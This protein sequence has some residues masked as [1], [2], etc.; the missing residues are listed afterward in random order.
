MKCM[1]TIFCLLDPA[2][3]PQNPCVLSCK[4][5]CLMKLDTVYRFPMQV[6]K[7]CFS[8]VAAANRVFTWAGLEI[9]SMSH[10]RAHRK[11][12]ILAAQPRKCSLP[13]LT[14]DIAC[15]KGRTETRRRA[16]FRMRVNVII[17]V[18]S[19]TFL[20]LCGIGAT[21][22]VP[23]NFIAARA[24]IATKEWARRI[25]KGPLYAVY[26]CVNYKMPLYRKC[27]CNFSSNLC[28]S[29]ESLLS[30]SKPQVKF[31]SQPFWR[32][33]IESMFSGRA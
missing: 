21:Q 23:D 18:T 14:S 22:V 20:Y 9:I 12:K 5:S 1:F 3:Y 17:R 10:M 2:S 25:Q 15:A 8:Q 28:L 33:R 16:V 27:K 6:M 32:S 31:Q 7:H 29:C 26:M 30:P 24:S 13:I 4:C 11:V 19:A